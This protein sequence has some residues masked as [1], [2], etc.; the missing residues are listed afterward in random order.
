M[1]DNSTRL[2]HVV[3]W[4]RDPVAAADFYEKTVGMEP[5][6]ITEYTAGTVSFPSVRLNE[7]TIFDLAPLSLAERMNMLPGAADSAGHPVN[8]VCLSLSGDSFDALRTRLRDR[9]VP[10]SELSY[11]S[12]GARGTAKRSFYFRDPDGN[13]FEARH[14]A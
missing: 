11:D 3:L 9:D 8:H 12:Y 7:E 10:V 14:Y 2:D 6:R 5:L 1:T 13:V 4:V